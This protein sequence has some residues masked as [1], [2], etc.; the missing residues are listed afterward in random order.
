MRTFKIR[1]KTRWPAGTAV[2]TAVPAD[3]A[4]TSDADSG[5]GDIGVGVG[6][7]VGVDAACLRNETPVE[8]KGQL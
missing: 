4:G 6:V 5:V 3:G 2:A 7:G 1:L 8:I